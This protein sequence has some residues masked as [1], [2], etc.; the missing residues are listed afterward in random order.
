MEEVDRAISNRLD[1]ATDRSVAITVPQ[2]FG[3]KSVG[4][5]SKK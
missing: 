4:R 2:R 5:I 1:S 3:I